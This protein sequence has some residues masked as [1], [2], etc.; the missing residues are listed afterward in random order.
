MSANRST[1][2]MMVEVING[3]IQ[4]DPHQIN[5]I[6]QTPINGFLKY[7]HDRPDINRMVKL[8]KNQI[9]RYVRLALIALETQFEQISMSHISLLLNL[10]V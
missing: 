9:G 10:T 6:D 7:W 8:V 1:N 3:I 2:R 5:G 4:E